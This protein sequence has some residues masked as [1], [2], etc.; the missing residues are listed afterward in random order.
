MCIRFVNN[1]RS[2][3]T[4]PR[5]PRSRG[6]CPST[7][8][9]RPGDHETSIRPGAA[10]LARILGGARSGRLR[11]DGADDQLDIRRARDEVELHAVALA[12]AVRPTIS[13]AKRTLVAL[14]IH[15]LQCD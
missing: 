2:R 10:L 3:E 7:R 8:A 4:L 12:V 13:S 14:E 15:A 11:L 5:G 1:L 9:P 6:R